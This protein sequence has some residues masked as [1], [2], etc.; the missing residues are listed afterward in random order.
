ME[1]LYT[2][3]DICFIAGISSQTVRQLLREGHLKGAKVGRKWVIQKSDF[4]SFLDNGGVK[5]TEKYKATF[6]GGKNNE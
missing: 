3:E 2:I 4:Q 6:K 5:D 1:K